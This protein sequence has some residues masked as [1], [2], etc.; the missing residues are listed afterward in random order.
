MFVVTHTHTSILALFPVK[1]ETSEINRGMLCLE[2]E[3]KQQ[4]ARP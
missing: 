2:E 1:N 3:T 4:I